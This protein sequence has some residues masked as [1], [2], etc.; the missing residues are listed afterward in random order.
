MADLTAA[1]LLN[2]AETLL[3]EAGRIDE[4]TSRRIA[5][6]AGTSHTAINY[7]FGSRD[8]LVRDVMVRT[9]KRFH[10]RRLTQLQAAIDRHAPRPPDLRGVLA[11]LIEPSVR[12]AAD[13]GSGYAVFRHFDVLAQLSRDEALR[14]PELFDAAVHRRFIEVLEEIVPWYD[15]EELG[16][17]LCAV[18]GLRQIVLRGD[19]RHSAL[20]GGAFDAADPDAVLARILT[21][22]VALFARPGRP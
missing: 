22:S 18:L 21:L 14:D 10:A 19:T 5:A 9:Y 13:P 7:H 12:W 1:T 11:A 15:A 4:V 16:W 3:C 17:R 6:R 20:A 2:A 8:R